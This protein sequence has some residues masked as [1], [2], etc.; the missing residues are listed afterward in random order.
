MKIEMGESLCYSYLRHVKRCWLVQTNW[1]VSSHWTPKKTSDELEERFQNMRK[2]FGDK[3]FNKTKKAEQFLKQSE[4]DLVGID[5]QGNIHAME[6]AFHESG[7]DYGSCDET[8]DR[9][10]KK[11]LRTLLTLQ[12]YHSDEVELHIYFAAPKVNPKPHK[13]LVSTFHRLC[14]E[15]PKVKWYLLTN[16]QFSN[17]ILEATLAK[18]DSEA[19]TTELFAR[20]AKLLKLTGFSNLQ[21][22]NPTATIHGGNKTTQITGQLQPL[23]KGLMQTLLVDAPSLLCEEDKRN[24]MEAEYC[25]INLGIKIGNLALMRELKLGK[26]VSGNSRYYAQPY[27]EYY[28]CS[29]WNKI[30]SVSNARSLLRFVSDLASKR[31][32]QPDVAKLHPHKRTL[33]AFVRENSIA[34]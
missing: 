4:V 12:A 33:K 3:T 31:H 9:V 29:Q 20:A 17:Q 2:K 32:A 25:K 8:N 5:Q 21:Q 18:T 14:E 10:L 13:R 26:S 11:M 27:G 34:R 28:V 19:D 30:Y 15:Y 6:I 24:L 1:K 7:L 16:D 22:L 23:V